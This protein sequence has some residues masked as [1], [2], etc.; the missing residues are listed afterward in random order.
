[1]G[2][3]WAKDANPDEMRNEGELPGGPLVGGAW[4]R[5]R[6]GDGGGEDV[7]KR[8]EGKRTGRTGDRRKERTCMGQR[9]CGAT[10]AHASG[11]REGRG[12][13]GARRSH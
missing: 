9:A 1:M 4:E 2:S 3:T 11:E 10:G 13:G 8:R 6:T 5:R 12:D 7:Q